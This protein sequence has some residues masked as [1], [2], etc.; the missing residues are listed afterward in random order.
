MGERLLHWGVDLVILRVR[1]L[2]SIEKFRH[3]SKRCLRQD[4]EQCI[5]WTGQP[6]TQFCFDHIACETVDQESLFRVVGQPAVEH[7]LSGYNCCVFVY[8][9]I[10]EFP[11]SAEFPFFLVFL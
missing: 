3:E 6:Q 5:T 2:N 1:P 4:N 11:W 10:I 9:Q 7:C 8:E